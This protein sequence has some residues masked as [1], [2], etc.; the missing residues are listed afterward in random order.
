M[1]EL[2]IEKR[3]DGSVVISGASVII[4]DGMVIVDNKTEEEK[5]A[6]EALQNQLNGEG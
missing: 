3:L 5:A 6:Q 1:T 4:V 2:R